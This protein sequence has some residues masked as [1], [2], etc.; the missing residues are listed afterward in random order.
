MNQ[1]LNFSRELAQTATV[2]VYTVYVYSILPINY[3]FNSVC[4]PH[5]SV[6]W[7]QNIEHESYGPLL[8]TFMVL[9]VILELDR[10]IPLSPS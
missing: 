4:T 5:K 3:I 6:V 1:A 2:H 10:F 7:L 8:H 9:F